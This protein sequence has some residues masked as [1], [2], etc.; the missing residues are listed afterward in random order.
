MIMKKVKLI[1]AAGRYRLS[2]AKHSNGS[3][4]FLEWLSEYQARNYGR[5]TFIVE[6]KSDIFEVLNDEIIIK[7]D[8]ISQQAA[9]YAQH[10]IQQHFS[11]N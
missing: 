8:D 3:M 7:F 5:M 11:L 9:E 1:K 6:T 2:F 10:Y 4:L